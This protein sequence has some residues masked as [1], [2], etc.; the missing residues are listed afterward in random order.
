[1]IFDNAGVGQTQASTA[2]A[3]GHA[4]DQWWAGGDPRA[5]YFV[6]SFLAPDGLTCLVWRHFPDDGDGIEIVHFQWWLPAFPGLRICGV[7]P[8]VSDRRLRLICAAACPLR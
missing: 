8:R 2:T 6:M 5:R 7:G 3:Q 1:M 4:V